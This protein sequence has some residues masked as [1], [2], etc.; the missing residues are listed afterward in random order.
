MRITE[1]LSENILMQQPSSDGFYELHEMETTIMDQLVSE[2][3]HANGA[4]RKWR[5]VPANLIKMVW[6][7][8]AK[9]GFVRSEKAMD[10]ISSLF[11]H[12][13]AAIQLNNVLS[14]HDTI[15]PSDMLSEYF[16]EDE[17]Q[18]FIDWAIDY[19]G[20]R[21]RISDY[22]IG[23]LMKYAALLHDAYT[24]EEKLQ[25]CD[26][27]LNVVHPRS[28]LASWFVEGGSRTL[29]EISSE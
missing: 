19:D 7:S 1:I 15:D 25:I 9:L 23:P 8:N 4:E 5:V 28:D 22:G 17:Y 18:D 16:E 20:G 3:K 2:Y 13:T 26:A 6:S 14:G 21:W 10:K 27:M 12:N 24:P 29:S 11:I